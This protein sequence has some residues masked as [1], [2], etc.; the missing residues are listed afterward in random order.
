[1]KNLLIT[2]V[3]FSSLCVSAQNDREFAPVNPLAGSFAMEWMTYAGS[4]DTDE[5]FCVRDMPDGGVVVCG[6]TMSDSFPGMDSLDSVAGNYDMVIFR[7]DSA[8]QI[9]WTTLYGGLYYETANALVVRDTSIYVIGS[10]NG[11]DAPMIN[12]FQSTTGGSYDA[13]ILRLGFDG[14][15]Q[16]SSYFGLT[17]AEQGFGIDVDSSGKIAI[18]GSSTSATLP[19]STSGYQTTNGGANDC[20]I[21]VLDSSFAPLWTT[22]IGGAGTEDV[23]TL[24]ITPKN[25][26]VACGASFSVNFPCTPNAFQNGK[27]GPNDA[28]FAVFGMDGSR[29]YAT[30]YGGSGGE[31]CFGLAGDANG[32][33]YLAGH[34]SSI[35]FNTAGTIFQPMFAGINDTWVARFDSSGVPYFSTFFGGAGEEFT[36]AMVHREGYLFICGTTQSI[37]LPMNVTAPQ[38]SLWGGRDG[39]IVKFDT[40]GNYVTSTYF[41]GTGLD[42]MMSITVNSDTLATAVGVSYSNNLPVL[43]AYQANYFASG[44]GFAVRYKLSEIWSSSAVPAELLTEDSRIYP[45]PASLN[46]VITTSFAMEGVE[47]VDINGSVVLN[48]FT[49]GVLTTTMDISSLSA[50]I[51]FVRAYANDGTAVVHKLMKAE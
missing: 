45:N 5:L 9:V 23:H 51:Y 18:G 31:D 15:I 46:V 44:D 14:T 22:F 4:N 43:N 49:Q 17:G 6:R 28:Y 39:F 2:L 29:K 10:T 20:F 42:E 1:M 3:L 8:G 27:L 13:I 47:I 33:I 7:M 26:I 37:D 25:D 40:A 38:D 24:I 32:N 48:N 36:W 16:Q 41:G 11:N 19:M 35:D 12:A 30:Y 50:G 21:T 34:T